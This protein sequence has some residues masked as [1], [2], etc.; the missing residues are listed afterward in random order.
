MIRPDWDN[1]YKN[2]NSFVLCSCGMILQHRQITREH[3][4]MGHFDYIKEENRMQ[5]PQAGELW[6]MPNGEVVFFFV[7]YKDKK[8]H[9]I[10]DD[11]SGSLDNLPD[12]Y[13]VDAESFDGWVKIG[14]QG[15]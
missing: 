15:C 2:I 7:F 3:W 5:K 10:F 13:G 4:Q 1:F 8:L 12:I 14:G 9:Y 6:T 11:G